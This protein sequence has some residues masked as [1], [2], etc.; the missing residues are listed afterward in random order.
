MVFVCAP[1]PSGPEL[2][3]GDT[4]R[5]LEEHAHHGGDRMP[6]IAEAFAEHGNGLGYTRVVRFPEGYRWAIHQENGFWS[7]AEKNCVP[8]FGCW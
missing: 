4:G 1:F 2:I 7:S 3:F 8:A 6:R 5:V